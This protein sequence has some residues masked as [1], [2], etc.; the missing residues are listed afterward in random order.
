LAQS[1]KPTFFS[2]PKPNTPTPQAPPL[3]VQKLTWE[4]M[5][6]HQLNGLFYNCDD[7]YFLGHKCKEHKKFMVISEDVSD[8]E[9]EASPEAKLPKIDDPTFP[10]DRP[11][12]EPMI[13][14]N[15][16]TSF[17]S[18]ETLKLFGYIKNGKV[19][20]LVNSG[21]N[22]NLIHLHLAQEVNFYIHVVNNFQIMISNGG[23]MK[24]GGRCENVFL[25]IGLY[26]LKSHMFSIDMGGCEIVLGVE[27]LRTLGPI[28]MDFNELTMQFQHVRKQYK[29]QGITTGSTEIIQAVETPLVHPDL[30]EIISHHPTNLQTA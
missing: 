26:N 5:D 20:I 19:I 10:S 17:S 4:E 29:V 27:W 11:E 18:L 24:C 13:S 16:I 15:D 30:E 25:Q 21:S 7:K 22:H 28:T 1:R 8:E 2:R 23:S 3:K 12:V 14:L 9:V 6:E